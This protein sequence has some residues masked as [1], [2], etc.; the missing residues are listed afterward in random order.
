[1]SVSQKLSDGDNLLIDCAASKIAK[2]RQA[3]NGRVPRGLVSN[4]L[5]TLISKGVKATRDLVNGRVKKIFKVPSQVRVAGGS[6][7]VISDLTSYSSS[8]ADTSTRTATTSATVRPRGRPKG[9]TSQAKRDLKALRTRLLDE[10]T[11]E[12]SA[13]LNEKENQSS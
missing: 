3:N 4:V 12:Y 1:M 8:S 5:Q 2:E 6:S 13:R 9:S 11:L 10:V 7:S